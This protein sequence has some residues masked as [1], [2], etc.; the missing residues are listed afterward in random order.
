MQKYDIPTNKWLMI[1]SLKIGKLFPAC[2]SFNERFIYVFN[3]F[4]GIPCDKIG[5]IE[6]LDVQDEESGWTLDYSG[7]IQ[8]F[9]NIAIITQECSQKILAF[10]GSQRSRSI[11][12]M[13]EFVACKHVAK[14]KTQINLG[15]EMYTVPGS[16][17]HGKFACFSREG[18]FYFMCKRIEEKFGLYE[19]D[20]K[21]KFSHTLQ[22]CNLC[23]LS[24][25]D[26]YPVP[27]NFA[28]TI[29]VTRNQQDENLN[30]EKKKDISSIKKK[31]YEED[32]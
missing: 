11:A 2:C 17:N 13:I 6:R 10:G 15:I 29:I 8:A 23:R 28:E 27:N 16:F 19:A 31:K 25:F 4:I 21:Q 12:N 26:Y 14:L 18:E 3:G 7:G 20:H 24:H 1:P 5:S 32:S 9:N 30:L 22:S